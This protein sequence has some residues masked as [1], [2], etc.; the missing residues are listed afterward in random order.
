MPG[1]FVIDTREGGTRK[2][3]ML[4]NAVVLAMTLPADP[5][6]I[7]RDVPEC[8]AEFDGGVLSTQVEFAD[9]YVVEA[10]W[11]VT[12]AGLRELEDGSEARIVN[13]V[14]DRIVETD[15]I[16]RRKRLTPF[17]QRV[18]V[19]FQGRTHGEVIDHAAEL[20]CSTVLRLNGGENRFAPATVEPM[21][22]A[23]RVMHRPPGA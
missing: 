21:R 15:A 9:G 5:A 4:I 7:A 22:V 6:E 20:W 1:L 17:A 16:T 2:M 14:L 13:A 3:H 12:D 8:R 18:Q 19:T 23:V 11:R 10:P